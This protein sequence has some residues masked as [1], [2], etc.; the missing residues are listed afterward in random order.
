MKGKE[1]DS[2]LLSTCHV[3]GPGLGALYLHLFYLILTTTLL[4]RLI[5]HI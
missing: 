1:G 2:F 3:S 5:F 4:G